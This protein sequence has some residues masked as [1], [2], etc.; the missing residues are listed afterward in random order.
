MRN[1]FFVLFI[2][3]SL[4]VSGQ[5]DFA[6]P[7]DIPLFLSGNFAELRSNHFHTGIDIKTQG[8]EGKNIYSIEEGVVSRIKV[9]P[10]GYGRALYIDHPSGYT[11]VYGHLSAFSKKIEEV[12]RKKQYAEESFGVDFGPESEITVTKGELIA[13]SGNSGSSGGPHLHFEIRRTADSHPLNP[14]K[15][16]FDIKD[17]IPPRIRGVRFHPLSDTTLI[18]G[19]NEAQSFVIHGSQGKYR[20]KSGLEIDVYGAFG[21]S[22]HTLDYLDGY[23]NKCGV[24]SVDLKVDDEFISGQKF[25][26]LDFSTTRHINSYKAYDVY[27]TN[28]WHYHKSFIDPGND[29]EIYNPETKNQGVLSFDKEGTHEVKYTIK[30]AYGNT[31]VLTFEFQSLASPNAQL[32]VPETYDAF[33]SYN[34]E[35]EFTYGDEISLLLP[36]GSLYRD[37]KFQFGREVQKP[38]EYSPRYTLHRELIPLQESMKISIK[39]NDVPDELRSKIIAARYGATGG[40]SFLSGSF[41]DNRFNFD[42]R[43]FGKFTLVTD[44]KAPTIELRSQK[45]KLVSSNTALVFRIKDDM[46]G[47]T[48]YDAYFNN[49]WV[50]AEYDPKRNALTVDFEY[51]NFEESTGTLEVVVKDAVGNEGR[52]TMTF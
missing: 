30:D 15:Y 16:D 46:A 19:E 6:A 44:T 14:L 10:Y 12:V 35:N 9:S 38:G 23:P 33:F 13:L 29:L 2:S 36:K 5:P 31:S 17:N 37:L 7:M 1:I 18:N 21:I 20:L 42:S 39:V 27:H 4:A 11:S 48:E 24:Y 49:R 25:D 45:P 8:V 22:I 41:E 51:F 43:S 3:T 52:E 26:E 34:R 50:L 47:I 40:A 32:P 28:R